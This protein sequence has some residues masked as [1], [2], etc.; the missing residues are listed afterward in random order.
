M[1]KNHTLPKISQLSLSNQVGPIDPAGPFQPFGPTPLKETFLLIGSNEW[2]NTNLGYITLQLFWRSLPASFSEYY[3]E[4]AEVYPYNNTS[5]KVHFSVL[6]KG[7]WH[8][9]H[10]KLISLF[11]EDPNTVTFLP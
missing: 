7:S 2:L 1:P 3:K 11:K 10:E 6:H 4:Y 8:L 9:L 5:F